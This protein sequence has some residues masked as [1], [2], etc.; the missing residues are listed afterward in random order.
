M[1]QTG[2]TRAPENSIFRTPLGGPVPECLKNMT[3]PEM[4]MISPIIS[5]VWVYKL[6]AHGHPNSR[7]RS[8]KGNAISFMNDVQSVCTRLPNV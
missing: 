5:K 7:Q 8:I 1:T 4:L 6:V 2:D 3:L